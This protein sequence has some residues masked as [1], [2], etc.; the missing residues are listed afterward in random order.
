[1]HLLHETCSLS[2]FFKAAVMDIKNKIGQRIAETRKQ[3]GYTVKELAEKTIDL[4]PSR[5]SNWEQGTRTP[6]PSE[7]KQLARALSVPAAYLLCLTA[8]DTM[9]TEYTG[10]MIVPV[11]PLLSFEQ[12]A[13]PTKIVKQGADILNKNNPEL[14]L[15]VSKSLSKQVSL[16][17]FYLTIIDDSMEPELK[18][19]DLILIN[20]QSKLAPGD[21]VL[22]VLPKQKS[23]VIRKYREL[24]LNKKTN[25]TYELV[26]LNDDWPSITIDNEKAKAKILGTVAELRRQV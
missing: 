6:G 3:C 12:A 5:I 16:D 26:S 4:K 8:D 18:V 9:T 22:V 21:Y 19:G 1:M 2:T 7:T 24:S 25:M 10:S 20:T 11:L 13:T 17:A 23:P 14:L 15:P